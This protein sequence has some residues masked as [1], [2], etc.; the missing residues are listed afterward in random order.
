MYPDLMDGLVPLASQPIQISGRNWI[1]R[2]I[3][4][5]AIKNDPE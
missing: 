3:R 5:E 1:N 4:I 2:R